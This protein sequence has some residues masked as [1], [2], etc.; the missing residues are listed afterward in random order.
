M[1]YY[2]HNTNA[3]F[4]VYSFKHA[5]LSG[6]FIR[7]IAQKGKY[8]ELTTSSDATDGFHKGKKSVSALRSIGA[9]HRFLTDGARRLT[10]EAHSILTQLE[11]LLHLVEKQ[12]TLT[13]RG[14]YLVIVR[15]VAKHPHPQHAMFMKHDDDDGNNNGG[16]NSNGSNAADDDLNI[17][18][19]TRVYVANLEEEAWIHGESK[20]SI[21]SGRLFGTR[22]A[23]SP[24][25][26]ECA[27]R[28]RHQPPHAL[29]HK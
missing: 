24:K 22:D 25:E 26:F 1:N 3:A 7:C 11:R 15:G 14:A 5:E 4:T 27:L 29:Q 9:L 16:A 28:V 13:F 10:Y 19:E 12:R 2:A 21:S 17:P 18:T 6:I 8:H 23:S 20:K